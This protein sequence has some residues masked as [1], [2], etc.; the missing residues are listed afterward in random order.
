VISG[1]HPWTAV[2]LLAIGG[3]VLVAFLIA[4]MAQAGRNELAVGPQA[5]VETVE[6][7][8]QPPQELDGQSAAEILSLRQEA[9]ARYPALLAGKYT[10]SRQVF[11]MA[12]GLPWWGIA[13][14]F[15]H[16]RGEHSV[17]G[18][19]EESRFILNP[20]LL[21]GAELSGLSIWSGG[22][23]ALAWDKARITAQELADPGF[24]FYC[25]PASLRW[26]PRDARAEVTYDLSACL[27]VMNTWTLY[28][29]R[30]A[31]ASFDLVAYNAR[32]LG[33]G[34]LY[35]SP[36]GSQN[37]STS[38]AMGVP[39]AISQFIHRG[40]SCGF[41]GGCNNMSPRVP[42]LCGIQIER[43]PARAVLRLWQD[44]PA[45]AEEDGD[46]TVVLAFR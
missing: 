37:L 31:D 34:Y 2:G 16:G 14:H 26:W 22:E 32:D 18:P 30:V 5:S 40:D 9:I 28:P 39:I 33:L 4:W 20:Y 41:L 42:E 45:S 29:L 38:N 24:P 43:L 25:P 12:G 1:R 6:I 21:V 23:R 7:A 17:D 13:G 19:A 15:Y 8:L 35:W 10:P 44:R 46:M 11:R 27:A 36:Q 3:L